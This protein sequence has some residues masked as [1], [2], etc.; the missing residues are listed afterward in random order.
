MAA[1]KHKKIVSRMFF[2]FLNTYKPKTQL[3]SAL[4]S[5]DSSRTYGR[6]SQN[7][8]TSGFRESFLHEN[9]FKTC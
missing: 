9:D 1:Q 4:N 5:I 8:I 6:L 3:I 2:A 7:P